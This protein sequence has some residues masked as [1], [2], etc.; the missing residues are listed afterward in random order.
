MIVKNK[1][2]IIKGLELA[3]ADPIR[4]IDAKRTLQDILH[5]GTV[6]KRHPMIDQISHRLDRSNGIWPIITVL[7]K[8]NSLVQQ[9]FQFHSIQVIGKNNVISRSKDRL[10]LRT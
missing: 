4:Q 7:I 9:P 6:R 2:E 10:D 1:P 5:G 8:Q 3:G